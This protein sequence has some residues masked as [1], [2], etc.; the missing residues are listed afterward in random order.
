MSIEK[1][2]MIDGG[3]GNEIEP[4]TGALDFGSLERFGKFDPETAEKNKLKS[5]LQN[6]LDDGK[7]KEQILKEIDRPIDVLL[8]GRR[9]EEGEDALLG[10]CRARLNLDHGKMNDDHY[11]KLL[12]CATAN[13]GRDLGE[14]FSHPEL[15]DENV[16]QEFIKR[17]ST[18]DK[19]Q[20]F[21]DNFLAMIEKH[22]PPEKLAEY[23]KDMEEFKGLMFGKQ[24]E[25]WDV[26]KDM[27]AQ[28]KAVEEATEPWDEEEE[29]VDPAEP[30]VIKEK[31]DI[32]EGEPQ[33]GDHLG[34]GYY[35]AVRGGFDSKEE[36]YEFPRLDG[37]DLVMYEGRWYIASRKK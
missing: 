2:N 13:S 15:A 30:E 27:E 8:K 36:A 19:F 17:Y 7:S 26:L 14:R 33:V 10:A 3:A 11:R 6:K 28:E 5:E 22:N 35:L 29:T 23:T 32:F 12:L 16:Y 9:A 37:Q 25:T 1:I 4:E 24:Q 18:A 21:S 20:H 31:K 34:N